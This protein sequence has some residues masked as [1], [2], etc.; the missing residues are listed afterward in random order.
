MINGGLIVS[1]VQSSLSDQVLHK[2][3]YVIYRSVSRLTFD[4]SR[5][6]YVHGKRPNRS[7]PHLLGS[8]RNYRQLTMFLSKCSIGIAQNV[9]HIYWDTKEGR[10]CFFGE[11]R[12]VDCR[13]A[14]GTFVGRHGSVFPLGVVSRVSKIWKC[15]QRAS[16]INLV[17]SIQLCWSSS[18]A[19]GTF[20]YSFVLE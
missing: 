14:I 1:P 15:F 5:P 2:R 6:P 19:M 13:F 17:R 10:Q 9:W 12:P 11:C 20:R 16:T 7:N 4:V 18:M 3:Q 8:S